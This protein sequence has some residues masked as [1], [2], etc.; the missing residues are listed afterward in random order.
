MEESGNR[1]ADV[2][3]LTKAEQIRKRTREMIEV[4]SGYKEQF[5]EITGGRDENGDLV[6]KT[7]YD[8]VGDYMMPENKNNGEPL[9]KI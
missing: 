8:L 5:I 6:G 3:I 4:L 7:N 1:P 9:K 2:A